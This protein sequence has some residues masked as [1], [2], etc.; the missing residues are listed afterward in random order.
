MTG[1]SKPQT[2]ML[3]GHIKKSSVMVVIDT[4]STHKFL[5]SIMVKRLNIFAFPMCNMKVMVGD[6]KKIEKVGKCHKGK[7]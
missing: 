4:G 3:K 1:I 2:L 5:D 7:L 6:G